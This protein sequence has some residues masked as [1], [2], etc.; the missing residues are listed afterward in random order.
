MSGTRS[1]VEAVRH[2][3]ALNKPIVADAVGGFPGLAA[4]AFGGVGGM[5]HGV[6]QK[7][8]CRFSDWK[9]P[10]SGGGG[11]STRTYIVELDRYLKEDQL[12]ALFEAHGGKAR[13]ACNDSS[14]CAH[15]IEDMTENAHI[16][17][18]TQ[19]RR[20]IDNLSSVPDVKRAEH[21]VHRHIDP[22]VRSA[23]NGARLKI[24]D[25]KVKSIVVDARSRLLRLRDALD[26]LHIS[27]E[28]TGGV[29][30]S[31]SPAFRGDGKP[32]S[33]ILSVK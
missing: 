32:M 33:A 4:A 7:E 14:C 2:L 21:F 17:F 11:S 5:C 10:S 30:R 15:G 27:D 1:F 23:R 28:R 31:R 12:N 18:L 3:H 16:H 22:A 29:S 24:A 20:Q 6:G 8:S 9:R 25:E 19:R 13:F 26:D